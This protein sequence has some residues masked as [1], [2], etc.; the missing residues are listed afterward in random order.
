L[1]GRERATPR[2]LR[3]SALA[4]FGGWLAWV[5]GTRPDPLSDAWAEALVLFAAL[6][7]VPL[8]FVATGISRFAARI[9]PYASFSLIASLSL[10][11]GLWATALALPWL[12][13]TLVAALEGVRRALAPKTPGAAETARIAALVFLP[14]GAGWLV[15]AR[16]GARPLGFSDSI[17]LL[18]A[19]HFHYAGFALP[20]VVGSV[21]AALG[22]ARSIDRI[23]VWLVVSGVPL[24]A[25]GITAT[26]LGTTAALEPVAA[27]VM[28]AGGALTAWLELE[29]ARV[30]RKRRALLAGSAAALGFGMILAALYG[31][32]SWLAIAALDIPW[33]RVLHGTA[34]A[35]GFAL[36][37]LLA[38]ASAD[39][40]DAAGPDLEGADEDGDRD[41]GGGEGDEQ[42]GPAGVQ[43]A[44][45]L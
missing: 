44:D 16:F 6:V 45:R 24:V 1:G 9:L 22:R 23:A 21:V 31:A 42:H 7:V 40:A 8:G 3:A 28:A 13:V 25:A 30:D 12:A 43:A 27:W 33:M 37:A 5:A 15:L 34:N 35:F 36:L 2:S 20:A 11:R 38:F 39:D 17:V 19:A 14:I 10:A 18:T 32:R 29:L 41:G 26:Q 4:G